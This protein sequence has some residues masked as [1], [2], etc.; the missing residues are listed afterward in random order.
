[1]RSTR[2]RF[3]TTMGADVRSDDIHEELWHASQ[4]NQLAITRSND[5]HQTM[6]GAYVNEEVTPFRWLR[7]NVGGRADLLS[8]AVDNRLATTDPASPKS[9]Q[10]RRAP[11]QPQGLARRDAARTKRR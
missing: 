10:R 9:G 7:A 8:F 6:L 11:I 3:D 1:M 5:V 2:V 4:R